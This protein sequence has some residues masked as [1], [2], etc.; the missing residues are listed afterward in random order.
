ML[1]TCYVGLLT[2]FWG[3]TQAL[4]NIHANILFWR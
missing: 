4:R 3:T 2:K 1:V